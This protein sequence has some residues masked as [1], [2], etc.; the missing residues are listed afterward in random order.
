MLEVYN[1]LLKK[2][3]S[4]MSDESKARRE[5]TLEKMEL[6]QFRF[7]LTSYYFLVEFHF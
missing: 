5:K 3:T 4:Q 6:K 2:D 1:S 7:L